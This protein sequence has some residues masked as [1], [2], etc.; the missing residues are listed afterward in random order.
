MSKHLSLSDRSLIEK[1][2]AED[3]TFAYIAKRLC[4]SPATISREIRLHRCFVERQEVTE[5]DCIHY[6]KC[7]KRDI[8][9]DD[10]G[11]PHC[12]SLCKF[13][14]SLDCTKNC[15]SYAS[16]HCKKLNKPPYVCNGCEKQH[17]CKLIHAYYSAN[18]AHDAYLRELKESRSGIRTTVEDLER[19]DDLISPLIKK[20][21]SINHIFASHADEIGVSEKT[22]YTYINDNVFLIRNMDLP[23]KVKYKARRK[24]TSVLTRIEYKFRR[25]RTL[26]DF[27][28]FTQV[29]PDLQ[30][31]EM[32]TVKG[33][34]GSGKVLLTFIFRE[35]NFMLIFLLKD[36]TQESVEGVFDWLTNQLGTET[37]RRV[38]PVILTDNGVEFKSPH[39][40]EFSSAG[41]R[42]TRIFYCDPQASW[43]KAHVEKN[44]VLIRRILPKGTSFQF[45]TQEDATLIAC[46]VNSFAREIFDNKTPFELMNKP[47]HKKLLDV[48][49][50]HRI[51]PD[52]VCLKPKLIKR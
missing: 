18:R 23:K 2:I 44:H 46:H 1:F 26:E 11:K 38:F 42:R 8:C 27:Q 32:D 35:S 31:V 41:I 13:C 16:R 6:N 25:G 29:N 30:I 4:R 10:L 17:G 20:G 51:P 7:L 52:E 3:F 37:F 21:Q 40:L 28:T 50:L 43:Q 19:I 39:N 48:L 45:L 9:S 36:D 33:A 22:L 12:S 34:R 24:K 47:E 14:I 5:N 15:K 49:S